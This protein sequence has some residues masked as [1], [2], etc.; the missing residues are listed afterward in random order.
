MSLKKVATE[1]GVS[2]A[3][4]SNALSGRG[5]VS[6]EL[7]DRIRRYAAKA[8]YVPSQTARALKSGRTDTLGLV[9][10]DL[11]N[12][13]FPRIAQSLAIEADR[14]GLGVLIADSRGSAEEQ[15]RALS[16]LVQRGVDGILIVPQRGT[17]PARQSV[18]M[19]VINAAADPANTVS[20]D[21]IG[22]GRL[23]G[24]HIAQLGH[25]DV[26]LIGDPLSDVQRDRITGMTEALAA[27]AKIRTRSA[28][29]GLKDLVDDIRDGATA[30][31]T[32]S[33]LLALRV[34]AEL[35]RHGLQ[36]PGDVSLS[37]IDDLPLS[38]AMHPQLTTVAQATEDIAERAI[39]IILSQIRGE[40]APLLGQTIPMRL[41]IRQST[42][43]P[44]PQ[45]G[46][47]I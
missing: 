4:V 27:H 34:L 35:S 25:K 24:A 37:G 18:P 10:P 12:P 6:A 47:Q 38:Q 2:V 14:M 41:V 22:G 45:Q 36:V 30:V 31:L 21:H 40:Q 23:I 17:T 5:R 11:T 9:M 19:V 13:L 15:D 28:P 46:S 16:R 1:L 44:K 33:D 3:T 20:A 42:T 7:A 8:G 29:D 43:S 32:T 26:V 39:A